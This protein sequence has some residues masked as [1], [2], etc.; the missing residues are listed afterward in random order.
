[1]VL[2]EN[3]NLFS[4]M[5]SKR[6]VPL[7]TGPGPGDPGML[8]LLPCTSIFNHMTNYLFKLLEVLYY[9]PKPQNHSYAL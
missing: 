2:W 3:V 9:L 6:A 8:V 1:M 5:W 4:N 7:A